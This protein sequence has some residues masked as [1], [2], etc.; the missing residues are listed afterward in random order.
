MLVHRSTSAPQVAVS[1][2]GPGDGELLAV[3]AAEVRT[4]GE[5]S[6]V[7]LAAV[8]TREALQ[9]LAGAAS[10]DRGEGYA[11]D[12]AVLATAEDGALIGKVRGSRIYRVRLWV[13]DATLAFSCTCPVGAARSFCKHCVAVG[14]IWLAGEDD[15]GAG[16]PAARALMA[17]ADPVHLEGSSQPL[18]ASSKELLERLEQAENQLA[19][20]RADNERLRVLLGQ[21]SAGVPPPE[22]PAVPTLFPTFEPPSPIDSSASLNMKVGLVRALF[23][24]QDEVYAVRWTNSRTGKAGYAPAVA[25]ASRGASG[26]SK[27]HLPLTDEVIQ[28]HQPGR[29]A[30]RKLREPD[31]TAAAGELS[32]E[33]Q[34]RVL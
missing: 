10:F 23:R 24:G 29:P 20:L 13:Q 34:H 12:G 19:R 32:D 9:R 7:S 16:A 11:S 27:R 30:Q 25:G 17:P 18:R 5:C 22:E 15:P 14:L 26:R 33:W 21:P 6:G 1:A 2:V 3:M 8:L 31:R 4:G 28:E